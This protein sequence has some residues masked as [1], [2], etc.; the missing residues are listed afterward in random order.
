MESS[1]QVSILTKV[2]TYFTGKT[3]LEIFSGI[4]TITY[5]ALEALNAVLCLD[6][7]RKAY[8]AY[9]GNDSLLPD[10]FKLAKAKALIQQATSTD[11]I[12][13]SKLVEAEAILNQMKDC[14]NSC[15]WARRDLLKG[16]AKIDIEKARELLKKGN[17]DLS[18]FPTLLVKQIADENK[19][20]EGI[21]ELLREILGQS[22]SQVCKKDKNDLFSL[23]DI[24]E[25]YC[26]YLQENKKSREILQMIEGQLESLS[27][28]DKL[29]IQLRVAKVYYV[30]D[31]QAIAAPGQEDT[32][33]GNR[34]DISK[35]KFQSII[36]DLENYS[37][38]LKIKMVRFFFNNIEI[39]FAIDQKNLPSFFSVEIEKFLNSQKRN[40][41]LAS[42]YRT[43]ALALEDENRISTRQ[44][45]LNKAG[46]ILFDCEEKTLE[47]LKEKA[48]LAQAF[49]VC[50]KNNSEGWQKT[51]RKSEKEILANIYKEYKEII[52]ERK[53]GE[54]L[55]DAEQD[56]FAKNAI[57]ILLQLKEEWIAL[58]K[59][60]K[61]KKILDKAEEIVNDFDF[62]HQIIYW[63]SILSGYKEISSEK[64]VQRILSILV[65]EFSNNKNG[66][67]SLQMTTLVLSRILSDNAL[68][69]SSFLDPIYNNHKKCLEKTS[70]K[71]ENLLSYFLQSYEKVNPDKVI[72]MLDDYKIEMKN[73]Q[74]KVHSI[75]A[76]IL[77]GLGLFLR[78]YPQYFH[79]IR[80][81]FAVLG[82]YN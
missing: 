59:L 48:N 77:A 44:N 7:V 57:E 29:A 21:L 30:L 68:V 32:F 39:T 52:T 13:Q 66:L 33:E 1:T 70:E 12:D 76:G 14:K 67:Y 81:G 35:K 72:Q 38:D 27:S 47:L 62:S 37:I 26:E 3:K 15:S 25:A 11:V 20:K 82:V 78:K 18:S 60:S 9:K 69:Q 74:I 19:D 64:D 49:R 43:L 31:K 5:I 42:K 34:Y 8:L 40:I 79:P 63:P 45:L 54:I 53:K 58:N 22:M 55:E 61:A 71:T 6:H 80:F 24:A 75:S 50:A 23:M 10:N 51:F 73:K 16:W 41:E 17:I 2:H 56:L 65:E 36:D 4:A 28:E 46:E